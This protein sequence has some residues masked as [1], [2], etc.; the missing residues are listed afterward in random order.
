MAQILIVDD[1]EAV[2]DPLSRQLQKEGHV[3]HA[4]DNG[5][6]AVARVQEAEFDLIISDIRMP[7]MD[8]IEFL[9][10][11]ISRIENV[12][13][14][15][16]LTGYSDVSHAIRAIHVGAYDYIR[17]P[18]EW[19]EMRLAVN[20]ALT[21]R[22]D[23]K[24]RRDYQRDLERKVQDAVAELKASYDGTVVGFAALLEGKD[25]ST[26]DHCIRVRDMCSR[27]GRE[28]GLGTDRI[29]DLE[30]GAVLHDI[31]KCKV[32]EKILRKEGKLDEVE[33]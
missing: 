22:A 15:M 24:F 16:V 26:A 30:L 32:D 2:R 13:P 25:T 20:R 27:L 7:V 5:R 14:C 10:T 17:K 4:A 12:T 21:R 18:W 3:C 31:G 1:D 28:L 23:L 6:A 9:R 29:K 33:W 19:E 8:G 11:V